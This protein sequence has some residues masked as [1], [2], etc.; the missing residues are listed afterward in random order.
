MEANKEPPQADL[1]QDSPFPGDFIDNVFV[2]SESERTL[3]SIR[4][5]TQKWIKSWNKAARRNGTL[6]ELQSF[7][8]ANGFNFLQSLC[9]KGADPN[10]ILSLLVKYLWNKK[11]GIPEHKDPF[12]L[13]WN[14]FLKAIKAT[15]KYYELCYRNPRM[16][17]YPKWFKDQMGGEP[18]EE[19]EQFLSTA[20]DKITRFLGCKDFQPQGLRHPP[21]E[22]V[23]R[24]VYTI[25]EHLRFT[26]GGPQWSVFLDLLLAGKALEKNVKKKRIEY[27]GNNNPNSRL[28]TH[29]E[30]FQRYHFKEARSIKFALT[31]PAKLFMIRPLN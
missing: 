18:N 24:V 6:S 17:E 25:C 8:N 4:P 31:Q 26:T 22:K 29:L 2:I 3:F 11:V 13:G 19:V 16:Q 15:K 12:N 23:N 30:S 5:F 20:E 21:N 9:N 28:S 1:R 27:E 14:E 7:E 10:L